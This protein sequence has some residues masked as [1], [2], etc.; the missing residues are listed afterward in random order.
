MDLKCNPIHMMR[1]SVIIHV[2]CMAGSN[3]NG[4]KR[5]SL[6]DERLRRYDLFLS[7]IPSATGLAKQTKT[8][9]YFT[10]NI[11]MTYFILWVPIP[12]FRRQNAVPV[13][14]ILKYCIFLFTLN[15]FIIHLFICWN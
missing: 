6:F 14:L 13:K 3:I 9:K 5:S 11:V 2:Q 12:G 4:P 10:Q 8:D 7:Y 1:S 15:F